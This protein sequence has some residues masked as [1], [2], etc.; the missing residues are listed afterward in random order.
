MRVVLVFSN[1]AGGFL[2][3]LATTQTAAA[4][5]LAQSM[6]RVVTQSGPSAWRQVLDLL[7]LRM[8]R[9][10]LNAD[11]Y[12]TF[13]LW[14]HDLPPNYIAEILPQSRRK[15]FNQALELP[16]LGLADWLIND[17][18]ATEALLSAANLP[19][20]KTLA[21][22]SPMDYDVPSWVT[23]LPDAEA[24]AQFL[25]TTDDFPLFGKPRSD[26]LARG[27]V[28][29]ASRSDN[30]T[31]ITFLNR[32]SAPID[33]LAKEIAADWS[34]GYIFQ[35]F[36]TC[37]TALRAHVGGAMASLRIVTLR[38]E[39]G[40][41]PF[42]A[43]LRI[44]SK[45]AMHDGDSVNQRVWCVIDLQSGRIVKARDPQDAVG[46]DITHWLDPDTPLAGFVLPDWH[47]A[48][49]HVCAAHQAFP[50][51]GILGWDV[52]LTDQGPLIN[53]VNAN[54]G[55]VYQAA[56]GHGLCTPPMMALYNRALAYAE[57]MKQTL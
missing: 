16:Q 36:H 50:A 3:Y 24:I 34:S 2:K 57:R 27:A 21:S 46:P 56:A 18:V 33:D 23:L 29:I 26:S 7:R 25:K 43:I 44:P 10:G 13:S 4:G 1:H 9:M 51:H 39:E 31:S 42:Y 8:K 48:L 15:A 53:E 38:H 17:K 49:S 37:H 41:E 47:E 6:M 20:T 35:R 5:R 55:H 28:S 30:G 19:C 54:P 22:Y 45:T 12:Y 32:V 52:F 11:E 14:R 40:I